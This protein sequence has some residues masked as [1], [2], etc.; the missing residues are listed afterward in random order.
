MGI[1]RKEVN[2][3]SDGLNKKDTTDSLQ[4]IYDQLQLV[5][6]V[7]KLRVDQAL[8]DSFKNQNQQMNIVMKEKSDI[9]RSFRNY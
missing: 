5:D 6:H 9:Y 2:Q 8:L 1:A 4:H 7:L 3:V